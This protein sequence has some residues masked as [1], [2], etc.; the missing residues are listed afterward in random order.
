MVP[1]SGRSTYGTATHGPAFNILDA[2]RNKL[3]LGMPS[4]TP[5]VIENEM[6]KIVPWEFW[7]GERFNVNRLFGNGR[8]NPTGGFL[9]G[10]V[11]EPGETGVI[12]PNAT[13]SYTPPDP[14]TPPVDS[15][16]VPP[17]FRNVPFDYS[18]DDPLISGPSSPWL[19][20]R[21]M[22]GNFTA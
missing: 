11:D 17:T 18:N 9:N 3:T 22:L 4:A 20:R 6:H 12:W 21:Y 10:V 14:S 5:D 16:P 7:H 15:R 19:S 2:Y 13:D 8:D 1:A